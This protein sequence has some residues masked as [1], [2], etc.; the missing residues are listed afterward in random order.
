MYAY[1]TRCVAVNSSVFFFQG[2]WGGGGISPLSFEFNSIQTHAWKLTIACL[3]II[4]TTSHNFIQT[5]SSRLKV[6]SVPTCV[7]FCQL[8]TKFSVAASNSTCG[9]ANFFF[10]NSMTA[11]L[12]QGRKLAGEHLPQ[13]YP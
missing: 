8:D 11:N 9:K 13:L 2:L 3:Y 12:N 1:S 4:V 10:A 6:T 5:H 7:G